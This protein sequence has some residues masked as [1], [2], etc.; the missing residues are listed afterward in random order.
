MEEPKLSF[1]AY[2]E[3]GD[4]TNGWLPL[5]NIVHNLE[6]F[7]AGAD[8]ADELVAHLRQVGNVA[9][10]MRVVRDSHREEEKGSHVPRGFMTRIA[11]ILVGDEL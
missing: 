1:V 5:E 4:V 7:R 9:L 2:T 8:R 3:D 11:D 6:A 10:F